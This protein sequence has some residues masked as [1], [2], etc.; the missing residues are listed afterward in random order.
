MSER[1][2]ILF[3]KSKSYTVSAAMILSLFNAW[4]QKALALCASVCSTINYFAWHLNQKSS[5]FIMHMS[6]ITA[7]TEKNSEYGFHNS[8]N[9]SDIHKLFR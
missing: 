3:Q 1:T 8:D 5:I 6:I 4:S 7:G 9:R 2:C